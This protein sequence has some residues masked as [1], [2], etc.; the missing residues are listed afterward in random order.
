MGETFPCNF[1][2][3]H[4]LLYPVRV[5]SIFS[6][7]LSV[8]YKI[9]LTAK[10]SSFNLTVIHFYVERGGNEDQDCSFSFFNILS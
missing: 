3:K 8:D 1:F 10:K 7:I 5:G 6:N 2:L 9:F 4:R